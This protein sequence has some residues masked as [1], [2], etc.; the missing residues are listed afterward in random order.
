MTEVFKAEYENNKEAFVFPEVTQEEEA[1]LAAAEK[2]V[3][4]T[5]KSFAK[6]LDSVS[7]WLTKELLD[8]YEKL[9]G[10]LWEKEKKEKSSWENWVEKSVLRGMAYKLLYEKHKDVFP[11]KIKDILW[12]MLRNLSEYEEVKIKHKSLKEMLRRCASIVS[13]QSAIN[14]AKF[15]E[16]RT[17][18]PDNLGWHIP[19]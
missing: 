6:A 11:E 10:I 12:E 13:V 8:I 4:D 3:E 15:G 17:F 1:K 7:Q 18:T 19:Y 2:K 9:E 14:T 16:W 5:C